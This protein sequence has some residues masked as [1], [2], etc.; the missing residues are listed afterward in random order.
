MDPVPVEVAPGSVVVLG[1]AGI[2]VPG[3]DLSVPERYTCVQSVGD[4]SVPQGVRADGWR[5]IPATFAIRVT[6]R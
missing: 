5:G 1:S 4:G 6:M 2:G 3:Q